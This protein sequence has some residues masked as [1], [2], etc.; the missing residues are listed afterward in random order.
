MQGTL[1]RPEPRAALTGGL[2][3]GN[4]GS[5]GGGGDRNELAFS[6]AREWFW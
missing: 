2:K 5:G 6:R 1:S 4:P 3:G